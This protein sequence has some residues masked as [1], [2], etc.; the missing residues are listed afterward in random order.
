MEEFWAI[1]LKPVGKVGSGDGEARVVVESVA[2]VVVEG[3]EV[4]LVEII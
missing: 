4:V 1:M 2:V 3:V